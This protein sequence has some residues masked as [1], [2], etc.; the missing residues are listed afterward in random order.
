MKRVVIIALLI[1]IS[2]FFFSSCDVNKDEIPSQI[3][4]GTD[5]DD[6]EQTGD[7]DSDD[8]DKEETGKEDEN[9]KPTPVKPIQNGGK[10]EFD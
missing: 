10:I 5:I 9:N 2:L 3:E 8:N 4:Q 1:C 7:G 6:K